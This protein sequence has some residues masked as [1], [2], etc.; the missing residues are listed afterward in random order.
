VLPYIIV[1]SLSFIMNIDDSVSKYGYVLDCTL[2]SVY[3]SVWYSTAGDIRVTVFESIY[4]VVRSPILTGAQNRKYFMP[5]E[6]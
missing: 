6:P 3:N 5:Y 1:F 2:N 4:A